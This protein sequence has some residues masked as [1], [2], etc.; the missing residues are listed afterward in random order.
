MGLTILG[1]LLV[2][3]GIIGMVVMLKG[4]PPS[5]PSLETAKSKH[6]TLKPKPR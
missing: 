5:Y 1:I 6:Q 4:S 3:M 2:A